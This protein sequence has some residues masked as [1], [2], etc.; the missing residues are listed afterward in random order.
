[1]IVTKQ[2]DNDKTSCFKNVF[3]LSYTDKQLLKTNYFVIQ[4]NG[5]NCCIA[6]CYSDIPV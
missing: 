3:F 5:D 2:T 1:M 6:Q 4:C